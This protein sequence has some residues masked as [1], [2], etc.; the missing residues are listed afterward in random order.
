MKYSLF[1]VFGVEL[2]YMIIDSNFKISPVAD[3]LFKEFCDDFS[4]DFVNGDISWSNELVLHV[5]E[6][7]TTVPVSDLVSLVDKFQKDVLVISDFFKSK[8][9][10]LLSGAVHPLMNPF[11]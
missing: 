6:L 7:K 11:D 5:V 4:G 3:S 9:F 10:L 1:E 8:G 2:E